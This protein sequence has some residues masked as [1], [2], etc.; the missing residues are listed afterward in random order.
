MKLTLVSAL[1]FVL[2]STAA[3]ANNLHL[4]EH[5]PNGFEIYRSGLPT[6]PEFKGMCSAGIH[7]FIVLSGDAEKVEMKFAGDCPGTQVLYNVRQDATIPLTP[8]FLRQFDGW[9]AQAR[10]DGAKILF[11]CDCGCHRTGRLAAYYRMKYD[12]YTV[13]Q[14]VSE[15]ND[16][17]KFMG[18]YPTLPAQVQALDDYVH[19]RPC[20]VSRSLCVAPAGSRQ[21]LLQ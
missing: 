16:L 2:G 9:V 18:V 17:G 10:A 11:R 4:I 1:L 12:G 8:E 14:A 19:G 6:R 20:S 13:A 5:A 15:M 3:Q 7:R 21:N